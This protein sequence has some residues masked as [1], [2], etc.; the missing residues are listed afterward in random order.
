MRIQCPECSQRFDVTDDFLGKTVECGSCDGR[1]KVSAESIVKDKAKFYPGEKRETHLERFGRNSSE[2]GASVDFQQAHYQPDVNAARIGPPRPR[3]TVATIVGVSLMSLVIVIFLL[4]GGKEGAMRDMETMNRFILV[5]FTALLGGLLVIYGMVNN[6]RL[7]IILTAVFVAL[8]L[9]LPILL[10]ANPMNASVVPIAV[11]SQL[12]DGSRTDLSNIEKERD[13][14]LFE[15]GYAPV[16]EALAKF[17]K[18]EVVGIYLRNASELVSGKIRDYMY[19]ATDKANRGIIYERGEL[20]SESL[21]LLLNQK[22][23]IDEIALLCE[24]FGR[25]ERIEKKLSLIDVIVE[26]S[27]ISQLDKYKMLDSSSLDFEFQNLQALKSFDPTERLNAVRRLAVAE[28]RSRRDDIT[29]QFIKMIPES[30]MELQLEIINALKTWALPTA[31]AEPVVLEAVKQIHAQGKVDKAAMGF[32]VDRK[33]EG[34]EFILGDLWDGN[35]AAWSEMMLQL[36]EGAQILL[37]P[38]LKD[39]D[40]PHLVSASEILAKTGTMDSIPLL[41][42]VMKSKEGQSKKSLQA[43][44]DEIKKRQ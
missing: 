22:R 43:A 26:R 42:K 44:I 16:K 31:G 1:F 14:Y 37:L 11:D 5:G 32:L 38:K 25:I 34:C 4:T 9:L 2:G 21:I 15:I 13:D 30:S 24:K 33:V 39:M 18:D 12:G 20:G 40:M 3:R 8:L 41:E 35:P 17:P 23:S 28:P 36:G 19:E 6:R 10:P 29:Q 27:K 7:G